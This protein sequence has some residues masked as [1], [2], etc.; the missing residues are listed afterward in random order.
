MDTK[1]VRIDRD[2]YERI[3]AQ[4]GRDETVSETIERLIDGTCYWTLGRATLRKTRPPT[5][6]SPTAPSGL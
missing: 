2:L 5:V 3:A 1:S 6:N 4:K